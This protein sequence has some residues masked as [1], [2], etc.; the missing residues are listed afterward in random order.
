MFA[1]SSELYDLIY[2]FKDYAKE[3]KEIYEMVRK[4]RPR[5]QEVLD[6][7]CGTGEHHKYLKDV[8]SLSGLDINP[9]FIEMAKTKVPN[10]A[11]HIGDMRAFNLEKKFDVILCLFS[12]IAYVKDFEELVSTLKNFRSHLHS[13]GLLIVEP[14]LAPEDW[15]EGKLHMLTYEED[16]IKICRMNQSDREGEHSVINFHYLIGTPEE[17]V[18]HFEERHELL[19]LSVEQMKEAFKQA[20]FVVDH[21]PRGLIGRGL[22]YAS[23]E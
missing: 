12:S 23:F 20:G 8:Y 16:G 19:L 21:E 9:N 11:Y 18:R 3:S 1:E 17:G 15:Y 10:A 6:V 7:G 5:A 4:Y 13:D 22:Y 2:S 14:W